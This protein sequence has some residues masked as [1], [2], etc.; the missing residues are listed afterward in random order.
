MEKCGDLRG[1]KMI[2]F[3]FPLEREFFFPFLRKSHNLKSILSFPRECYWNVR[4]QVGFLLL[5]STLQVAH[6]G[7]LPPVGSRRGPWGVNAGSQPNAGIPRAS[8]ADQSPERSGHLCPASSPLISQLNHSCPGDE[9]IYTVT[10]WEWKRPP[11]TWGREV[12][13]LTR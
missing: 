8:P 6:L 1:W 11:E 4:P 3:S 12:R 13:F 2:L 9:T 10:P 7:L 5:P